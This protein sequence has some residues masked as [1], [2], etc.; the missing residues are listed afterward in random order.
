MRVALQISTPLY[1]TNIA[2]PHNAQLAQN[3]GRIALAVQAYQGGQFSSTKAC[4]DAYDISDTTLRRRV[5]GT[6]ARSDSIPI[7]RKLTT[8]EESTLIEWILSIDQRGLL[9][10]SDSIRQI[11]NLLLQK[12]SRDNTLTVGK[13]WVYNFVRRHDSL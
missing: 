9:V 2:P 3:E 7:N 8:T 10:R 12:R 1:H 11:A 6:N 4:A 13:Q 5:K